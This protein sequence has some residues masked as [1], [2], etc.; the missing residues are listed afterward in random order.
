MG[1]KVPLNLRLT[2][3]PAIAAGLNEAVEAEIS[4]KDFELLE[5]TPKEGANTS[6]LMRADKKNNRYTGEITRIYT[7]VHIKD[8]VQK[9]LGMN[10]LNLFTKGDPTP[11]EVLEVLKTDLGMPYYRTTDFTIDT[12]N[13]KVVF[14]CITVFGEI[15]YALYGERVK[16][17]TIIEY[18]MGIKT[19]D[20]GIVGENKTIIGVIRDLVNL[21][22]TE[23][24]KSVVWDGVELTSPEMTGTTFPASRTLSAKINV[25]KGNINYLEENFSFAINR[26]GFAGWKNKYSEI[27]SSNTP[28]LYLDPAIFNGGINSGVEAAVRDRIAIDAKMI[29][30]DA[31]LINLSIYSNSP[32][33]VKVTGFSGPYVFVET[34]DHS[35]FKIVKPLTEL[36][37]VFPEDELPIYEGIKD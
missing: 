11:E 30:M 15:P 10:V 35:V 4:H 14:D 26:A 5:Y 16:L 27:D 19:I 17:S 18:D 33:Q 34:S 8:I 20:Y 3:E 28:V 23:R 2:P 29:P 9:R 32:F 6:L 25:P 12:E 22:L 1:T 31:K 21:K 24:G 37:T 7:R 36:K 13:K